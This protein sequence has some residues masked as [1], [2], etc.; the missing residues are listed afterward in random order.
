MRIRFWSVNV[1]GIQITWDFATVDELADAYWSEDADVPANDDPIY[2]L[3]FG[4][5]PILLSKLVGEPTFYDLI[6]LLGI[7]E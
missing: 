1:D 3:Y 4:D 2:S 7:D 5:E 6:R